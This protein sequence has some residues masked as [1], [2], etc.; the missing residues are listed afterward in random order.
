MLLG[1]P[2]PD[3]DA[4]ARPYPMLCRDGSEGNPTTECGG[5]VRTILPEQLHQQWRR[6][7]SERN[8]LLEL[9][10]AAHIHGRRPSRRLSQVL[11]FPLALT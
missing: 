11:P 2:H 3:Y 9:L 4:R 8:Q 10:A 7:G 1:L 5:T 6:N